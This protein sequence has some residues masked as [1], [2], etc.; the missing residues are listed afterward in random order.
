[1]LFGPDIDGGILKQNFALR[2]SSGRHIHGR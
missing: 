1:M 2:T